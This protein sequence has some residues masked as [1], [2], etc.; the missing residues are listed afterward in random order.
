MLKDLIRKNRTY[1]RYKQEEPI[2]Y[3]DVEGTRR[4]GKNL[5]KRKQYAGSE[6]YRFESEGDE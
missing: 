3:R 5:I 6:I 1:R 4:C 2:F